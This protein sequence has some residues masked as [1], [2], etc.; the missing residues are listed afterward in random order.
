M[1]RHCVLVPFYGRVSQVENCVRK[2]LS[3]GLPDTYI[4][5]INDGTPSSELGTTLD[6]LLENESLVMLH[7]T[8]NMGVAAAR[9]TGVE[10]A[11]AHQCEIVI[12][13]D[14]DC[15]P[16]ESFIKQHLGLHARYADVACF[17]G[18][19]LGVGST[20]WARLDNLMSWVH[21]V[22]YGEIRKVSA[23]YHLPT[24]NFSIKLS[25]VDPTLPMFE[26]R[27]KTGEDALLIRQLRRSGASV[28][29]SPDPI[30]YHLDRSGLVDVLKH[31]YEWGHH[32]YFIQLGGDFSEITMKPWYRVLFL[33]AFLPFLPVF[34]MLGAV[35]NIAPW[36][37][38]KPVYLAYFPLVYMVWMCKS[39]AVG[40]AALRPHRC[41]RL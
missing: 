38:H 8:G 29:F 19:I 15:I 18:G 5:L 39:V 23:L 12:M 31:H 30:I 4:V 41:L 34:A 11:R 33:L 32:Q 14:S 24:T 25:S 37:K 20:L 3:E 21:S 1:T 13:I 26:S 6:E 22:P 36:L 35:L 28:M 2:L 9:N 40:E 7:H 27:L 17:G 10:W 16:S